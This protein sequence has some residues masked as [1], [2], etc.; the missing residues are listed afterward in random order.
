M[1]IP[2]AVLF[3][4]LTVRSPPTVSTKTSSRMFTWGCLPATWSSRVVGFHAKSC[5]RGRTW[6]SSPRASM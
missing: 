5:D 2:V 3:S 4:T 1:P 6:S